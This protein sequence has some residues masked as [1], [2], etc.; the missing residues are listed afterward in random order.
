MAIPRA[1]VAHPP[2]EPTQP[3]FPHVAGPAGPV[4][5]A[6]PTAAAPAAAASG[7]VMMSEAQD[8]A[9]VTGGEGGG[10]DGEMAAEKQDEGRAGG[11]A[12]GISLYELLHGM[13]IEL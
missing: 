8:E 10:G 4:P 6:E 3:L 12:K 1:A 5:A 13:G 9:D 11:E 7:D 2:E